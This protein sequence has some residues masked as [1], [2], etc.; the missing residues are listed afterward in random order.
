MD[1]Y[2]EIR[3]KLHAED[4]KLNYLLDVFGDHIS[5]REGYQSLE[6]TG[7]SAVHYYLI[8]KYGWLPRDVKSMSYEDI[9]FVLSEEMR[10][11]APPKSAI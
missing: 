5:E 10:V 11:W 9:R 6:L 1:E 4:G 2:D 7:I 3:Y 8:T